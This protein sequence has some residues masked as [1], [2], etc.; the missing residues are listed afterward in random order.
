M[1]FRSVLGRLRGLETVLPEL[2][3][4]VLADV[5]DDALAAVEEA[6]EAERLLEGK[7]RMLLRPSGTEPLIRIFAESRDAEL[8]NRAADIMEEA[9]GKVVNAQ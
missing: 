9:I 2:L 5:L 7:G 4:D 8:M 1:A 6:D 3:A